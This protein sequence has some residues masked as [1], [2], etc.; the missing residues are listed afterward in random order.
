MEKIYLLLS[1]NPMAAEK[2]REDRDIELSYHE[3]DSF[4]DVLVRARDLIHRGWH[5]MT[6]PQA[7]NLKPNQCPYKTVFLSKGRAA[8]SEEREIE[9]IEA[10]I[11]AVDK[12][13]RGMQAPRWTEKAL[14]DFQ[15][16]DLSVIESALNSSLLHQII[17][18]HQ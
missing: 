14:R 9:L 8:E 1:N 2:Y 5:L 7:S 6:H 11:A 17:L 10:A 4:R 16:V 15:T 3:E 12:F 13:T 18:N